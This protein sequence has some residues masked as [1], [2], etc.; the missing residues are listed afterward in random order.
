MVTLA[1]LRG[2]KAVGN[3]RNTSLFMTQRAKR[4]NPFFSLSSFLLF[5]FT[6]LSLASNLI[7]FHLLLARAY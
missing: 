6:I 5:S 2:G 4:S 1:T 7:A 3:G